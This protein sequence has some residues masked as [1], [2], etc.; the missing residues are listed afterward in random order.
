MQAL[1]I[2]QHPLALLGGELGAFA[3]AHPVNATFG[4]ALVLAGF[5]SGAL[6]GLGFH[7]EGFLGGYG[8]LRRRLLRLGHIALIALGLLNVVYAI[9]P[10]PA[11][12]TAAAAVAG[13]GLMVGGVSMPLACVLAAWR[14]PLRFL[15]P[16]PVIA[17]LASVIAL[18]SGG[19]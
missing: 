9:Y 4:W 7:R 16:V 3:I 1:L 10:A 2:P 12:G 15:F 8:S 17:L 14:E 18:L 11:A 19:V 13:I 5:A 6:L